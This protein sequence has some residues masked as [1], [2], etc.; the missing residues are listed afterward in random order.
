VGLLAELSA[1]PDAEQFARQA[2]EIADRIGVPFSR[3]QGFLALGIGQ[4]VNGSFGDAASSVEEALRTAHATRTGLGW[5]PSILAYLAEA[6]VE[7]GDL[8]RARTT[9]DEAVSVA[10]R[11][12]TLVY[13]LRAHLARVHVLLADAGAKAATEIDAALNRAGSL[14][15][16]TG[17]T[18]YAP[19]VH[20][21]R[22]RLAALRGDGAA[23]LTELREAHRLFEDIGAKRHAERSVEELAAARRGAFGEI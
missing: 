15:D 5:E 7:S 21:A 6:Y 12:H 13:E 9:A 2:I 18:S 17:A 14:V 3:V 8:E 20:E 4:V 10:R 22:S 1:N 23:R 16:E 19:F 11:C